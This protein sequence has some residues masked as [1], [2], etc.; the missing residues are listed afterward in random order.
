M[1]IDLREIEVSIDD[2]ELDVDEL[3][4]L[5]LGCVSWDRDREIAYI[6]IIDI[7]TYVFSRV[8]EDFDYVVQQVK[9]VIDIS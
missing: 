8:P 7:L 9:Q 4:E 1:Y 5:V 3:S 2:V 6:N